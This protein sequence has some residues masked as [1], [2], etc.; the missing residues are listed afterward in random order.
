MQ[1]QLSHCKNESRPILIAPF[2]FPSRRFLPSFP[3]FKKERNGTFTRF[4]RVARGF[5]LRKKSAGSNG[6][7][8]R[9]RSPPGRTRL[10]I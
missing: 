7:G 8:L 3:T 6:N 4:G 9:R 2:S 10:Q 1:V 5:L